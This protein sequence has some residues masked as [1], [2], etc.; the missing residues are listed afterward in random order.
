MVVILRPSVLLSFMLGP[1]DTTRGP[2]VAPA[3]MVMEMDDVLQELIVMGASFTYTVLLPCV[4]PKPEPEI[5]T[6]SPTR[7]SLPERDVITG[8]AVAPVV[9]ETLSKLAVASTELLLLVTAIPMYTLAAILMVCVEPN[10]T[11]VAPSADV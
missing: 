7:T 9:S 11:Q 4:F 6:W 10:C 1:R 5:V 8:G 2:E 3:G